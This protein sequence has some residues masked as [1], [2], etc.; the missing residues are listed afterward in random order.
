V[1]LVPYFMIFFCTDR[2]TVTC[3]PRTAHTVCTMRR[4]LSAHCVQAAKAL[5]TATVVTRQSLFL[6]AIFILSQNVRQ[7]AESGA[8]IKPFRPL[9]ATL[10]LL[11]YKAT[12]QIRQGW[13]RAWSRA[14]SLVQGP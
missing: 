12:C 13:C 6:T 7:P 11:R 1:R 14:L 2:G 8:G 10:S 3:T 5:T 9:K 4:G